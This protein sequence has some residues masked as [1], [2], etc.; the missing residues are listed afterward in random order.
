MHEAQD[1]TN[2]ANA[3]IKRIAEAAAC[4]ERTVH[5]MLAGRPV[6]GRV[7]VRLARVLAEHGTAL[8]RAGL[9]GPR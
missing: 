9:G 7:G 1:T 4:D 2:D 5:K 8:R 3:L 6:R